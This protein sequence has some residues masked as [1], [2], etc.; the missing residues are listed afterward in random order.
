VTIL[1]ASWLTAALDAI[2][3]LFFAALSLP[4]VLRHARW[5][6][7]LP[8]LDADGGAPTALPR[9]S[10]VI[11]ARDEAAVIERSVRTLLAQRGVAIDV[12]VVSDRSVDATAAIV[13]AVAA[14]DPRVR[15]LEIR[16]LPERWLGKCYA[17]HVGGADAA[18]D[19]ILFTDADCRLRDDVI[20][21]A[22]AVAAR[23]GVDH[24]TLTPGVI[25][26]TLP[27][28]AWHLVFI[29]SVCNWM[30]GV[31]QDDPDW[32][33]GVGA[34]NLVRAPI[35]RAGGGHEA[36]RLTVMDDVR[37]GLLVRRAGGRTRA[38]LG[39][40]DAP[41][42]WG[43]T[44]AE[45]LQVTEKNYFAALDYRT[46]P[47]LIGPPLFLLP[48]AWA[49]VRLFAGTALDLA[50]GLS[51]ML[52]ALPALVWARRLRWPIAAAALAPALHVFMMY[53]VVRSAIVTLRRGGTRWRDTFYPIALLRDGALSP[54]RAARRHQR[55]PPAP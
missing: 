51:P 26:A 17:C 15:G 36:L 41:C 12:T 48:F 13:G 35:Y 44:I 18:G 53:A 28:R 5:V 11:A 4:A 46:L 7:R 34:F 1:P 25:Q 22:L 23:D 47:A 6:Q 50:T 9:V 42:D 40:D 24:V 30:A 33:I 52:L 14:E 27:A 39:G 10:V 20:A 38:F 29:T 16:E 37:L 45:V 49:L 21:R 3:L 43:R 2:V 31:N 32:H 55:R 8:P 19:W 54:A